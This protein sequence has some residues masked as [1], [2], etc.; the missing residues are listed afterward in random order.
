V[1]VG[2]LD[3]N[4]F[5]SLFSNL[6][7]KPLDGFAVARSD[8]IMITHYPFHLAAIGRSVGE[9]DLFRHFAAARSGHFEGTGRENGESRL[10]SYAQVGNFP[11]IVI[12]GSAQSTLFA[13][14][15]QKALLVGL[16]MAVLAVAMAA[17]AFYLV[18]ELRHRRLVER[19]LESAAAALAVA[20]A[21]D[22]L[23]GLANR[24]RFDQ[25]AETEWNRAIRNQDLLSILIVDVDF[26]KAYNDACG[27]LCGDDALKAVA[28]CIQATL[29]RPCDFAARYGGEEFALLLPNTSSSGAYKVGETLRATLACRAVHH[30]HGLDQKLSVSIGIATV[31]PSKDKGFAEAFAAADEALFRA[32]RLGRNRTEHFDSRVS[33]VA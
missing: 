22:G 20:A 1:V 15:Q 33:I 5:E 13:A 26:F 29:S 17:L 4:Y 32:K 7:S 24:R 14:W 23:T 19:Q 28:K 8:G 2:A 3:L 27:H 11:L 30:P 12:V 16:L 9:R 31:T 6:K 21:T 18:K 25:T 10:Y